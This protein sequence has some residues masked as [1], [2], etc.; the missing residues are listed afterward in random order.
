MVGQH[1]PGVDMERVALTHATY[2]LTQM[3]DMPHQRIQPSSNKF[4]V[5]K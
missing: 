2:R 5:K 4:T 1:H 3:I